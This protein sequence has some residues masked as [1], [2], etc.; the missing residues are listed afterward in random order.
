MR[1]PAPDA[2]NSGFNRPVVYYTHDRF[3]RQFW[4]RGADADSK[5]SV[6]GWVVVVE[7]L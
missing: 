1:F 4:A 3:V 7:D 5:G 6:S 2:P